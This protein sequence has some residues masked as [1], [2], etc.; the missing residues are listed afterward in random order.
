MKN[1][2]RNPSGMLYDA[3]HNYKCKQKSLHSTKKGKAK[4]PTDI[5]STE[6]KLDENGN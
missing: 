1:G 4:E 3:Y 6:K 2:K 5:D